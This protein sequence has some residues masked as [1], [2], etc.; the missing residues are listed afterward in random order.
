M[1]CERLATFIA[2]HHGS[3]CTNLILTL[4][5]KTMPS[6][7]ERR[8]GLHRRSERPTTGQK[9]GDLA[10]ALTRWQAGSEKLNALGARPARGDVFFFL[11]APVRHL[12]RPGPAMKAT[13][14]AKPR[15]AALPYKLLLKSFDPVFYYHRPEPPR[16]EGARYQ[17]WKRLR[18]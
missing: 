6:F 5:K 18:A 7:V 8:A 16:R 3:S 17:R 11:R 12:K 10:F 2:G 15:E 4:H 13:E 1:L 14:L 9:T